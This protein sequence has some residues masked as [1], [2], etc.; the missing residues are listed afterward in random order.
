MLLLLMNRFLNDLKMFEKTMVF[1]YKLSDLNYV[2]ILFKV[3]V[4]CGTNMLG[5]DLILTINFLVIKKYYD[6]KLFH[7][8]NQTFINP[9]IKFE[10]DWLFS[11]WILIKVIDC[12][13]IGNLTQG[14]AVLKVF[15][16]SA[17]WFRVDL[18]KNT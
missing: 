12:V 2:W 9:H 4:I 5:N 14:D 7:V 11:F 13:G 6:I 8:K 3:W 1:L 15:R 10:I 17:P 18:I 16:I